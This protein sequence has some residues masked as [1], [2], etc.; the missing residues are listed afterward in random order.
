MNS[1]RNSSFMKLLTVLCC[2]VFCS[3]YHAQEGLDTCWVYD[4]W[5]KHSWGLWALPYIQ[6]EPAFKGDHTF[7]MGAVWDENKRELGE[8]IRVKEDVVFYNGE[9]Y[10]NYFKISREH[11]DIGFFVRMDIVGYYSVML[12]PRYRGEIQLYKSRLVHYAMFT[13]IVNLVSRDKSKDAVFRDRDGFEYLIIIYDPYFNPRKEAHIKGPNSVY[14][15]YYNLQR[16]IETE[17]SVQDKRKRADDYTVEEVYDLLIRI[18]RSQGRSFYE[19][20]IDYL[21]YF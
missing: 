13:S 20:N 12:I 5:H 14:L 16:I 7:I 3:K 1:F 8:D 19:G 21:K 2:L 17:G 10:S 15:N 9:Y 11:E 18:N 4:S 6:F